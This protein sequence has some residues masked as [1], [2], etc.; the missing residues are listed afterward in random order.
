MRT[1]KRQKRR[2]QVI[3][4]KQTGQMK[5]GRALRGC[6]HSGD[7]SLV[8]QAALVGYIYYTSNPAGMQSK[9]PRQP[10]T[11]AFFKGLV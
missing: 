4:L 9:A 2:I 6:F 11:A 1:V 10:K 7:L 5:Q 8:A 3:K